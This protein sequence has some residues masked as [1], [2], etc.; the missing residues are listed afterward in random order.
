MQ[1]RRIG[2]AS[3][4]KVVGALYAIL[5]LI[6]GVFVA[7]ISLVSAG[8]IRQEHPDMLPWFGSFFGVGAVVVLPIV[9]GVL[10]LVFGAIVSA[11][12]NAIAGLVGGIEVDLYDSG[13]ALPSQAP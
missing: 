4:S 12:Y 8:F 2:V 7:C 1:L 6:A 3:A 11:L 9:Y 13:P 10:G 5:G